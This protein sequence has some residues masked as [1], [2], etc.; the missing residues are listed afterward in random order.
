MLNLCL[1][2]AQ[3]SN[4]YI[5]NDFQFQTFSLVFHFASK[6]RMCSQNKCV[7]YWPE[8]NSTKEFGKICVK[9]IEEHTAQD[10]IRREL[11]VTRLDRVRASWEMTEL[12]GKN[13]QNCN[14]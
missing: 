3:L 14:I 12:E 5:Q 10:Y 11:E 7:R 6:K 2:S 1:F 13:D 9:N 4:I 8:I